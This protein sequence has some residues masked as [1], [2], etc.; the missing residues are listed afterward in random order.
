MGRSVMP[1]ATAN[2]HIPDIKP[3]IN[4]GTN[5]LMSISTA[6]TWPARQIVWLQ[7]LMPAPHHSHRSQ[8]PPPAESVEYR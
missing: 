3:Q 5:C 1:A 7:F 2:E 4:L 6:A 8:P